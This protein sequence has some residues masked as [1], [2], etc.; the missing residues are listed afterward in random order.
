MIQAINAM[1]TGESVLCGD[2]EI[3]EVKKLME[4]LSESCE[5]VSIGDFISKNTESLK[6]AKAAGNEI[7]VV[8]ID[9]NSRKEIER[10]MESCRLQKINMVGVVVV[11]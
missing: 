2:T 11:E 6:N 7:L 1:Q 9:K 5:H 10:E 8:C 4:E 3:P